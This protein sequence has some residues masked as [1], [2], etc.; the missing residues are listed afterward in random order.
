[1]P[2]HSSTRTGV[3]K[4]T[5][6]SMEA[7]HANELAAGII[8]KFAIMFAQRELFAIVELRSFLA[9]LVELSSSQLSSVN[10]LSF[11]T[12]EVSDS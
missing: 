11:S 9:M 2:V 8:V 3:L 6:T 1:M 5:N 10:I 4:L 12:T 7:R